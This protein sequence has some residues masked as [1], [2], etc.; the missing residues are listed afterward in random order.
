MLSIP[1]PIDSHPS[2][3]ITIFILVPLPFVKIDSTSALNS[4][5]QTII[6]TSTR[7]P[8]P[9]LEQLRLLPSHLS[10]NSRFR[11]LTESYAAPAEPSS[12]TSTPRA[13]TKSFF[14]TILS[15]PTIAAFH[16]F[17]HILH[18][19]SASSSSSSA[20]IR[21]RK[22]CE[23]VAPSTITTP[24]HIPDPSHTPSTAINAAVSL[25]APSKAEESPIRRSW[26]S[27]YH[28]F[29]VH[30]RRMPFRK[31]RQLIGVSPVGRCKNSRL[32]A[33]STRSSL[34]C[35]FSDHK[36]CK[37]YTKYKTSQ[38]NVCLPGRYKIQWDHIGATNGS[39]SIGP[40]RI[41]GS[42]IMTHRTG[43]EDIRQSNGNTGGE[44]S[45]WACPSDVVR[46]SRRSLGGRSGSPGVCHRDLTA[47]LNT[48]ICP[49]QAYFLIQIT[50][51]NSQ[52]HCGAL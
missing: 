22:P 7:L 25:S 39:R 9:T 1:T 51:I 8:I 47:P 26:I 48:S 14:S 43:S 20:P 28:R 18:P 13:T 17:S 10:Y 49:F 2:F 27:S 15:A 45:C 5:I 11:P 35:M 40:S 41:W 19:L 31:L 38:M 16:I 50:I 29:Q 24:W 46:T 42:T 6:A 37:E 23:P 32:G 33:S 4:A 3:A 21:P 36:A 34:A 12:E 44:T 52:P 30:N